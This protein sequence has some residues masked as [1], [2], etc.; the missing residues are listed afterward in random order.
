MMAE[1]ADLLGRR[2]LLGLGLV[3]GGSA[4]TA[5]AAAPAGSGL[6]SD[7]RLA[8]P[9]FNMEA[10]ARLLGRTDGRPAFYHA[11]GVM[12]GMRPGEHARELLAFEGCAARLFRPFGD[13]TGYALGLREWLLFR[14]PDSGA[15]AE[16]WRNPYTGQEALLPHFRGGG[17]MA[18]VW[19]QTGQGRRGHEA[20]AKPLPPQVY[21]WEFDGDRGMCSIEQFIA[22]PARVTPEQDPMASTGA[23]RHE[24][25]VRSFTFSRRDLFD[26][27]K[28]F[29]STIETWVMKNDWMPFMMMGN[30]PGHHI[31]RASGRKLASL[32]LLPQA[33]IAET[34]RRWP[35]TIAEF[36]A[37]TG[38]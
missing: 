27:R 20:L 18:H 30:W 19:T 6:V 21:T 16:S 24:F 12:Y 28:P 7:P 23:I 33:F 13:G 11:R 3:L 8:D 1:G 25:Q 29:L 37:W 17:G 32:D 34:E 35:G 26:P 9:R 15:V 22:F 31:W 4:L 2:D 36:A 10:A 14:D 5:A 38:A